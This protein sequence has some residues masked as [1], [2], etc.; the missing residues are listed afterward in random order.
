MCQ[1][2]NPKQFSDRIL[3][4]LEH[5]AAAQ[6]MGF[7]ARKTIEERFDWRII[8]KKVLKVYDEVLEKTGTNGDIDEIVR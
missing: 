1:P 4:L 6:E 2:F 3:Y 7:Q 8:V 5:P